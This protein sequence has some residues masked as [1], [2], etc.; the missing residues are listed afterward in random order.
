MTI[1]ISSL[2]AGA[3]PTL[4]GVLLMR[5]VKQIDRSIEGIAREVKLLAKQDTA[6]LVE[7]ASVRAR[8]THLEMIVMGQTGG[9]SG[10]PLID[11]ADS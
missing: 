6:M 8:L 5:S 9:N 4:L 3:L 2:I 1:D 7:L 10:S 11:S